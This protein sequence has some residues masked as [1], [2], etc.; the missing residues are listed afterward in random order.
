MKRR[1]SHCRAPVI[2]DPAN[3]EGGWILHATRSCPGL[4]S[5]VSVAVEVVPS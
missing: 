2:P 5:G 3:P 4:R 1:C